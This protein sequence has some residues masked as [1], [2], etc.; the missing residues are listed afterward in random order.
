MKPCDLTSD[1][2]RQL[3]GQRGILLPPLPPA[4]AVRCTQ[5]TKAGGVIR[6]AAAAV[7]AA[8]VLSAA[9]RVPLQLRQAQQG[10]QNSSRSV[11]GSRRRRSAQPGQQGGVPA[12]SVHLSVLPRPYRRGCKLQRCLRRVP[13]Q[14]RQP[15]E[16]VE[17]G[18]QLHQPAARH[19]CQHRQRRRCTRCLHI[20]RL[21]ISQRCLPHSLGVWVGGVC[22]GG[23]GCGGWGWGGGCGG[24]G[25]GGG[26]GRLL[27]VKM[28]WLALVGCKS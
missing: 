23:G 28:N 9:R 22:G 20:R 19:Y 8:A 15:P 11:R 7:A 2:R 12:G 27:G 17:A 4:L 13:R 21:G 14:K 10:C 25:G 18:R 26:G 16:P 5:H 1:E 3:A 6:A 24:G